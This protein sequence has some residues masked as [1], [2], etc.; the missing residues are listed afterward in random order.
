MA[1]VSAKRQPATRST[2]F[3]CSNNPDGVAWVVLDERIDRACR[4]FK[5]YQ[6][7]L[8]ANA[9]RWS[10][11]MAALAGVIGASTAALETTLAAARAAADGATVDPWGRTYWEEPLRPPFGSIKVT[12]ALF[13][14]QGGLLVDENAR[15]L[16]GGVPIPGLYAAGGAA[17]G[18]SGHGAA[19][20]LAGNGLLSALGLG[21]LA[22]RHAV[23]GN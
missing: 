18:I 16:R 23:T 8:E 3:R 22:G 15:V 12:G 10:E 6:D 20:Y 2:R 5:D 9:V 11:D 7:L 4:A 21:Y 14:T 1:T 17:V 13:H 19:G